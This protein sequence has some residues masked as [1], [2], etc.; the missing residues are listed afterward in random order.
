MFLNGFTHPP[1]DRTRLGRADDY[2]KLLSFAMGDG[3]AEDWLPECPLSIC[4][5]PPERK[6]F[7]GR[8]D[9]WSDAAICPAS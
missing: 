1:I 6:R 3:A 5:R 4:G 8:F 2:L 9:T 7:L